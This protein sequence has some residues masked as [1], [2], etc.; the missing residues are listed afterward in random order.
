M[1]IEFVDADGLCKNYLQ[2]AQN[3][4]PSA[5]WCKT[6]AST[7][8]ALKQSLIDDGTIDFGALDVDHQVLI[9]EHLT[10][11]AADPKAHLPWDGKTIS[12]LQKHISSA[13]AFKKMITQAKKSI[14][15]IYG[16][17]QFDRSFAR[18]FIKASTRS[19]KKAISPLTI[20]K[21]FSN[22]SRYKVMLS[23]H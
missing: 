9:L 17:E 21:F 12:A 19:R 7:K 1:P 20:E 6:L 16:Y 15:Y 22:P 23:A 18:T 5:Q 3:C 10:K 11:L 4:Y 13:T 8:K 2:S 14:T